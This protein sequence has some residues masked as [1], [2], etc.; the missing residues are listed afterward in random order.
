MARGQQHKARLSLNVT[1]LDGQQLGPRSGSSSCRFPT[2][3]AL[4]RVIPDLAE[5][6]QMPG[7]V[8]ASPGKGLCPVAAAFL[9]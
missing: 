4:V 5:G 6:Q 2:G 9:K 8:A 7:P 3:L 1:S